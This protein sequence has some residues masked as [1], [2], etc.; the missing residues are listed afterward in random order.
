MI[1]VKETKNKSIGHYHKVDDQDPNVHIVVMKKCGCA[2]TALN[3]ESN[4]SDSQ[5][6]KPSGLQSLLL[7]GAIFSDLSFIFSSLICLPAHLCSSIT[8]VG[9]WRRKREMGVQCL[10]NAVCIWLAFSSLSS[11]LTLWKSGL[12]VLNISNVFFP[13]GWNETNTKRREF[14][15]MHQ[16][17]KS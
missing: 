10:G 8:I 16:A 12:M 6:C 4:E 11:L 9:R 14:P 15:I 3:K 5:T 7:Q 2:H 17:F 1:N 13:T